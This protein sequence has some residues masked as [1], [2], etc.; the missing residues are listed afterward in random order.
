[1]NAIVNAI[2]QSASQNRVVATTVNCDSG[3]VLDEIRNAFDG[4]IDYTMIDREGIDILD[5]WGWREETSADE[6]DW[7]LTVKFEEDE[8]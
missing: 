6:M 5:V 8:D 2:C 1:M 7:R 3:D 4:E